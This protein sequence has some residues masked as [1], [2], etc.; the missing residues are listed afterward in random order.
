[1]QQAEIKHT[2]APLSV[3]NSLNVTFRS[4]L[5]YQDFKISVFQ[6]FTTSLF[7]YFAIS[8]FRYLATSLPRYLATSLPHYL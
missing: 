3:L 2:S 6:D 8:L 4:G 5:N 1:M 7:R